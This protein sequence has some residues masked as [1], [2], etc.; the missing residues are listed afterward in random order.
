MTKQVRNEVNLERAKKFEGLRPEV[1]KFAW[2]MEKQLQANEHKGGWGECDISF[3]I[4]ELMMNEIALHRDAERVHIGMEEYVSSVIRR[5]A[6]V[7]NFAM[8]IADNWGN[9]MKEREE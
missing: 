2:E 8:M 4:K 1:A 3:L 7:A 6:N 9:L 5:A